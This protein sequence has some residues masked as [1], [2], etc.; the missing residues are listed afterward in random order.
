[1][2]SK[3]AARK[4]FIAGTV[5]CA[6]AFILLTVDS[7]RQIPA[8]TRAADL[9]E[10]AIR[11]K[12]LFDKNN[13]M[14][15]HTILGEGGYYAPELTKVFERRGPQF[16]AEM[17]RHPEMMYPGQRK[18]QKYDL[19][20]QDIGDLVEF[21]KW[22]GRMDLNGFPPK[23]DLKA[24]TASSADSAAASGAAPPPAIFAQVCT[25]CH[26]LNGAGGSV[27]PA[28]DGIGSRRDQAFFVRWLKDP[29]AVKADSKMPKLPLS[30]TDIEALAKFLSGITSR[31]P[32][33]ETRQ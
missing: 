26:S 22:I 16:I 4:F 7:I 27:G 33:E 31:Q 18:M 30:E 3:S 23:P 10:S 12:H 5:L 17:L 15:C 29:S 6:G 28:L 20:E 2:L 8:Q 21:L 9:S 19:S 25:A 1:M 14:G 32:I 11:G 24:P 13:C